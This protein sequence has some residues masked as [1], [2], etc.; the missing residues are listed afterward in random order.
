MGNAAP[1]V[2]EEVLE[3]DTQGHLRLGEESGFYSKGHGNSLKG[4]K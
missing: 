2:M 3:R 1:D 4:S